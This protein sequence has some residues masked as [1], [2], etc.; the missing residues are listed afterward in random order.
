MKRLNQASHGAKSEARG[1]RMP[2]LGRLAD[3]SEW[4]LDGDA[5]S[6][7]SGSES[8]PDA[9]AEVEVLAPV[10]RRILARG[11]ARGAE[12]AERAGAAAG[13]ERKAVKLAEL[14]PRLRL[15]LVKVEEGLCQGK[16]LWHEFVTKT[17]E[18]EREMEAVWGKRRGEKEKRKKVQKENL[19]RKRKE[20]E[21]RKGGDDQDDE[22]DDEK[23][24]SDML[25]AAEELE[26]EEQ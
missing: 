9:D 21:A 12:A 2:N 6:Y 3:V 13:V 16:V 5:G 26:R 17:K 14:G 19:E 20:V 18:E 22:E 4:L 8:E 1:K 11:R 7:T 10:Q 15:R 24:D 25:E 23:W